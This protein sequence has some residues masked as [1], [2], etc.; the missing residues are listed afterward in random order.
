MI[1]VRIRVR[2][3]LTLL[4]RRCF[5]VTVDSVHMR[6]LPLP[7][8]HRVGREG[9]GSAE[10][11]VPRR[12]PEIANSPAEVGMGRGFCVLLVCSV[13]LPLFCQAPSPNPQVATVMAVNLRPKDAENGWR[14]ASQYDVSLK[15]GDAVYVVL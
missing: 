1:S 4:G 2:K 9:H 3:K 11:S 5:P 15:V 12:A 10:G 6:T 14:G 7:F 13:T 8:Q